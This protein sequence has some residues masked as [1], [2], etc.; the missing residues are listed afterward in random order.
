MASYTEMLTQANSQY[1]MQEILEM[2]DLITEPKNYEAYQSLVDEIGDKTESTLEG[3]QK[4][5]GEE[6][7]TRMFQYWMINYPDMSEERA[8]ELVEWAAAMIIRTKAMEDEGATG[9]EGIKPGLITGK[10]GADLIEQMIGIRPG[11]TEFKEI[12]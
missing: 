4:S 11:Y 12:K 1:T 8:S 9:T 5:F 3:M 7:P 6:L 2:E 10:V